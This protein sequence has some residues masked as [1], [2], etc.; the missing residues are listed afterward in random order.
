MKAS[1]ARRAVQTLS[2]KSLRQI[3]LLESLP[4]YSVPWSFLTGP[5]PHP[6]EALSAFSLSLHSE[7]PNLEKEP[8]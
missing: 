1:G 4:T 8:T 2:E 7:L 5:L 3:R 6:T